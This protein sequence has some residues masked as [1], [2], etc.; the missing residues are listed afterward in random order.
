MLK[1]TDQGDW[2]TC[3]TFSARRPEYVLSA[4]EYA[5]IE[6]RQNVKIYSDGIVGRFVTTSTNIENGWLV[7]AGQI[8]SKYGVGGEAL[9]FGL[10]NLLP[11]PTTLR[12]DSRLAHVEFFDLRGIVSEAISKSATEQE[13][14][15]ACRRGA[16]WEQADSDGV[17]Y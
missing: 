2:D 8:D 4:N 13:T 3:F 15:H 7:L 1:K 11:S 16:D 5:V 9:R 6:V 10:K 14:W 12:I 17:K